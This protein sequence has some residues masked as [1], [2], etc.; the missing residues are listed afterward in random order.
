MILVTNHTTQNYSAIETQMAIDSTSEGNS[1]LGFIEK[2]MRFLS[3]GLTLIHAC[4]SH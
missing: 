2:N 4:V 1:V 3:Q